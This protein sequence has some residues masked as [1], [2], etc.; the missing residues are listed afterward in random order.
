[1]NVVYVVTRLNKND[2]PSILG[3]YADERSAM[4]RARQGAMNC[5][6]DKPLTEFQEP[7]IDSHI[8][9]YRCDGSEWTVEKWGVE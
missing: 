2:R 3:V 9:T 4:Y 8:R 5:S 1:M 7:T 6:Y